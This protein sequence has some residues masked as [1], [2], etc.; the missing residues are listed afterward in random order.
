MLRSASTEFNINFLP[1]RHGGYHFN[2]CPSII[3]DINMWGTLSE[4]CFMD[5]TPKRPRWDSS[6]F[7][8]SVRCLIFSSSHV[9]S[10]LFWPS[11][12]VQMARGCPTLHSKFLQWLEAPGPHLQTILAASIFSSSDK[13]EPTRSRGGETKPTE[14]LLTLRFHSLSCCSF[15]SMF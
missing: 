14:L 12:Q 5:L 15:N 4:R 2:L 1:C 7:T 8:L 6:V 3:A 9:L 11:C 13:Q 10:P